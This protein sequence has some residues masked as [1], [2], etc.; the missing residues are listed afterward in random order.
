MIL[1]LFSVRGYSQMR[2]RDIW[3]RREKAK[4]R[5]KKGGKTNPV[6]EQSLSY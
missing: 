3:E 1:F 5:V 4:E 2:K 6:G